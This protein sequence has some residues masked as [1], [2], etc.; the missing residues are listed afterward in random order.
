MQ[1]CEFVS[2]TRPRKLGVASCHIRAGLVRQC[3]TGLWSRLS[4]YSTCLYGYMVGPSIRLIDGRSIY[5]T[6]LYQTLFDSVE[7][8]F[9]DPTTSTWCRLLPHPRQPDLG[10]GVEDTGF[11]V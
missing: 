2:V 6:Y 5:S 9:C 7:I 1:R 3:R 8:G 10:R 4:T 11:R